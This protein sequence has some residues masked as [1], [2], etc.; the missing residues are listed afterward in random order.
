MPSLDQYQIGLSLQAAKGV[1]AA[2]PQYIFDVTASD[3]AP[4][5]ESAPR[6]ET[7]QGRDAGDPVTSRMAA[8]GG[9][10]VLARPTLLGLLYYGA[11]GALATSGVA[12]ALQH[13]ASAADDQPRFTLWTLMFAGANRA[14]NVR[15]SDVKLTGLNLTGS[16]GGDLSAQCGIVGGR[17]ERIPEASLDL[18]GAMYVSDLPLRVPG[19]SIVK[20]QDATDAISEFGINLTAEI[21]TQQTDS[22]FDSYQEPGARSVEVTYTEVYQNYEMF[23]L[24]HFG[25]A[26]GTTPSGKIQYEPVKLTFTDEEG[27]EGLVVDIPR[28]GYMTAPLSPNTNREMA[29]YQ[30][31]GRGCRP[32]DAQGEYTGGPVMSA[33]VKNAVTAYTAA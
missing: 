10:T 5:V 20:G 32:K 12:P 8:G 6:E 22:L 15:Y 30:I 25:G 9:F 17:F 27:V 19:Y 29:M 31:T 11:L 16:A 13:L 2:S 21:S 7:G 4:Q 23:N 1:P 33:T 18:T 3:V 28:F 14:I 26:A 24:V